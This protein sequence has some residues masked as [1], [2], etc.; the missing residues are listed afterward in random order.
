MRRNNTQAK[1]VKTIVNQPFTE[2]LSTPYTIPS[3]N[4]IYMCFPF[5]RL[6]NSGGKGKRVNFY[7]LKDSTAHQWS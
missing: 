4:A 6:T 2:I 7:I 1:I 5:K 3:F